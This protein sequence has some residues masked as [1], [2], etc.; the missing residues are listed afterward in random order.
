[1]KSRILIMTSVLVIAILSYSFI[2]NNTGK[3]YEYMTISQSGRYI[4]I[5]QAGKT[6]QSIDISDE[7]ADVNDFRPALQRV[8]EL[9]EQ[10][11]ELIGNS[12]NENANFP[13]NYFLLRR[14]AK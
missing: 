1:M 14:E 2:V 3:L 11:W 4:R 9:Q 6:Y 8:E 10:E 13:T 5:C 12:L 7:K